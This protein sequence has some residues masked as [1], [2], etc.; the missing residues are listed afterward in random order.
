MKKPAQAEVNIGMVG[1]VDHGKTT[2]TKA[3]TGKWTDTFSE[4]IKRGIS[5]RLGYADV[6]MYKCPECK[7][8]EAYSVTEKCSSC[9]K[10]SQLLRKVSI[11]DAPGHETLMATMISGAAILDGA[12]LVI[13]ANEACPQPQTE[14]HL[15]AIKISGIKNIVVAQNKIDLVSREEALKNREQIKAFLDSKEYPKTPIIP[16]AANHKTN[17]DV[18]LEAVNET[19]PTPEKDLES[20][21]LM[22]VARSFEVNRPGTEPGKMTGG[23][24]GGSIIKGRLKVGDEIEI[25]PPT[26]KGPSTTTIVSLSTEAEKIQEARPGGLI[27][28]GTLIDPFFSKNDKLKG[29]VIGLKGSVPEAR[30]TLEVDFHAIKRTTEVEKQ[31]SSAIQKGETVVVAIGTGVTTGKVTGAQKTQQEH[32]KVVIELSRPL[33]APPKSRA[34]ISRNTGKGWRLSGYGQVS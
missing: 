9:G 3:L 2:L 26:E 7:G 32:S 30:K 13:A 33:C 31:L 34:V 6:S 23:V 4:E 21:P 11:V 16:I 5:I 27:A 15:E 22:F 14:E 12:I 10:K 18:L 24:V 17:L 20:A 8:S 29:S 28:I 1:H 19:I 25:S